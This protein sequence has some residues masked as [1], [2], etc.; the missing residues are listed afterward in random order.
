MPEDSAPGPTEAAEGAPTQER[1]I[2]TDTEEERNQDTVVPTEMTQ[3]PDVVKAARQLATLLV[4]ELDAAQGERQRAG[5]L[6]TLG[7]ITEHRQGDRRGA[8]HFYLEAH[9]LCPQEPA[10]LRSLRRNLWARQSW[11]AVVGLLDE[12]VNVVSDAGRRAAL[13]AQK[14]QLLGEVLGDWGAAAK[15]LAEGLRLD[16][17]SRPLQAGARLLAARCHDHSALLEASVRLAEA[18]SDRALRALLLNEAGQLLELQQRPEQALERYAG[19]LAAEPGDRTALL[20]RIRLCRA[21]GRW[22]ELVDLLQRT[23]H[24]AG[25]QRSAQL[26]RA[27]RLC[28]DKLRDRGRALQLLAQGL[29]DPAALSVAVDAL[30]NQGD[31]DQRLEAA[32]TLLADDA[33][34]GLQSRDQRAELLCYLGQCDE[35]GQ[36]AAAALRHHRAALAQVPDHHAALEALLDQLST[37]ERWEEAVEACDHAAEYTRDATLRRELLHRMAALAEGRLGDLDQAR[38]AHVRALARDPEDLEALDA[39]RRLYWMMGDHERLLGI[40]EQLATRTADEQDAICYLY[41][42]A[43]VVERHLPRQD[44]APVFERIIKLD[45]AELDAL[46]ALDR[47]YSGRGDNERLCHVL[48]A[49]ASREDDSRS[50]EALLLRLA[51]A[52]EAVGDVASAA[53]ALSMATPRSGEWVLVRELRRLRQLQ[54]QWELVVESLEQEVEACHD[55]E[56]RAETLVTLAKVLEDRLEQPQRAA[57]ALQQVLDLDPRHAEAAAR[58][59]LLLANRGDWRQLA[60]VI[61]LQS[62]ALAQEDGDPAVRLELLGRLAQIQEQHLDRP[63]EA[64]AAARQSLELD[65]HNLA[66]LRLLCRL[67]VEQ[68]RWPEAAEAL[69]RLAAASD[70]PAEQL[71]VHGRLGELWGEQLQQPLKAISSLQNVL[72]LSHDDG[73]ALTRLF[74]LFRQVGDH[75]SAADTLDRLTRVAT[76]PQVKIQH[77]LSLAELYDQEFGDA[78]LAVEQLQQAQQLEPANEKV[79]ARLKDALTRLAQWD[80][81]CDVIRSFLAALPDD[82]QRSGIQYR[83]DLGQIMHRRLNR[84]AEGLEQYSVV[85]DLDPTSVP[86]RHAAAQVLLEDNH[87]DEAV[88]EHREV[89]AIDPTNAHSLRQ[90]RTIWTRLD[91]QDGVHA[92]TGALVYLGHATEGEARAHGQQR[93]LGDRPRRCLEPSAFEAVLVHPAEHADGR[94]VLG[95]LVQAAH[96]IYPTRLED[97]GATLD[98]ALPPHEDHPLLGIAR[99][100]AK[101]LGLEFQVEVYIGDPQA[102]ALD[103]LLMDPPALVAGQDLLDTLTPQQVRCHMG[104][105]LSYVRNEVWVARGRSPEELRGLV[106]AACAAAGVTCP[107]AGTESPTRARL[108]DTIQR[109]LAPRD[110]AALREACAALAAGRLPVYQDWALAMRHTELRTALWVTNDLEAVLDQV[111]AEAGYATQVESRAAAVA[112]NPMATELMRYWLSDEFLSLRRTL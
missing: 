44:A 108:A 4:K 71:A 95:V 98:S 14:G 8:I 7:L 94:G 82:R 25:A 86:A 12:E 93:D 5:L 69:T 76:E 96:L 107:G 112:A 110:R 88:R 58:M 79:L 104:R 83:M 99:Q 67:H 61:G 78:R 26:L 55:P 18:T 109:G 46:E 16:P 70:D 68:E 91:D 13:L 101:V 45:P 56:V 74:H 34:E 27:A 2:T 48:S 53:W 57:A 24:E 50:R 11:S 6:H 40:L 28:R 52:R 80:V 35:A 64:C 36:D 33:V 97:W 3:P 17:D 38:A 23:A 77:L 73:A 60:R 103:L 84:P 102:A 54:A 59:Q 37:E 49:L 72:T 42:K 9:Q 20:A 15:A 10:Y 30:I 85:I 92:A 41:E 89:L 75:D 90:L 87:L 111:L 43:L 21:L 39:L 106:E 105:L 65:P 100:V 81:L 32:R 66:A 19:A 63:R 62:D 22:E 29:T 31:A 1:F 47:I 51:G